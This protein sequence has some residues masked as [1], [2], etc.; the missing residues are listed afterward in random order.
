MRQVPC[1]EGLGIT[2]HAI[3]NFGQVTE[4]PQRQELKAIDDLSILREPKKS[5]LALIGE[6]EVLAHLR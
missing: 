1:N 5:I 3:V 6:S 2:R 4:A